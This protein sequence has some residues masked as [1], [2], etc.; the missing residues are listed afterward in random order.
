MMEMLQVDMEPKRN[1]IKNNFH[2]CFISLFFSVGRGA[3]T[4]MN[5]VTCLLKM[6]RCK[7]LKNSL[8][9]LLHFLRLSHMEKRNK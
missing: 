2:Q 8:F 9:N 5:K 6:A 4:S 7:P 1:V 3:V